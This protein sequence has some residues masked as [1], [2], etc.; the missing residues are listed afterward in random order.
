MSGIIPVLANDATRGKE[1]T[2]ESF[3]W[4]NPSFATVAEN[5]M[6]RIYADGNQHPREAYTVQ[7]NCCYTIVVEMEEL[8]TQHDEHEVYVSQLKNVKTVSTKSCSSKNLSERMAVKYDTYVAKFNV[9]CAGSRHSADEVCGSVRPSQENVFIG[10]CFMVFVFLDENRL[11]KFDVEASKAIVHDTV[12]SVL[13][14]VTYNGSKVGELTN[15]LV[16]KTLARFTSLSKPFKYVV[17]CVI[18]Q[19]N[20]TGLHANAQT[21]WDSE[22]DGSCSVRWESKTI[23][24]LVSVFG[25]KI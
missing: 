2:G 4:E 1:V 14:G 3:A 5:P 10:L 8:G 12:E 23:I 6:M 24:C 22:T 13:S 11:E 25:M 7:Y 19:A 18:A 15:E 20:A 9:P 21:Y 17:T 16:S